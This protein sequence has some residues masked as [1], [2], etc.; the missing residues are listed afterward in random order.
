MKSRSSND[1]SRRKV[2]I[3]VAVAAAEAAKT[4]TATNTAIKKL[5]TP[6]KHAFYL[7]I[8]FANSIGHEFISCFWFKLKEIF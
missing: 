6:N 2:V 7:E 5:V 1:S 8:I 4:A 3:A